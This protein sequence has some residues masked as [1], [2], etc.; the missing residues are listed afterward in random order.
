MI[1]DPRKFFTGLL[2]LALFALVLAL[3]FL[4][5]LDGQSPMI[6]LD[7]LYNSIS[8]QSA[9]YIPALKE[10][11]AGCSGRE[12]Q[13]T[14]TMNNA[15]EAEQAASMLSISGV[16]AHATGAE[17]E[18]RGGLFD[19]LQACLDDS[20]LMFAN[21]GAALEARCR[22]APGCAR[23]VAE[24]ARQAPGLH[25]PPGDPGAERDATGLPHSG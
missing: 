4:P 10:E 5:V 3:F 24:L 1:T 16:T 2:A 13:L 18:L 9:Y 15:V 14:A 21:N 20:D 8:K 6:Y 22:I 11:A 19:I 25:S 17:I 23:H 12:L 7:S